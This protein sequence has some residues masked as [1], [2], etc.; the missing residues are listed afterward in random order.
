LTCP[1]KP[2]SGRTKHNNTSGIESTTKRKKIKKFDRP[3]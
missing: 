3:E 2:R 1:S